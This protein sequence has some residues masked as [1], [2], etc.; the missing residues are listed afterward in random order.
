MPGLTVATNLLWPTA[1]AWTGYHSQLLLLKTASVPHAIVSCPSGHY[2]QMPLDL[3]EG[4]L[5]FEETLDFAD[6]LDFED[7]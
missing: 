7:A 3:D 4:I 2:R 6:A 5:D 1:W